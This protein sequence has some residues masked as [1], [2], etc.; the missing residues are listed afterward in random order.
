MTLSLV[1]WAEEA[2]QTE[3]TTDPSNQQTDVSDKSG[4]SKTV[5]IGIVLPTKDE[6]R[7]IQDETRFK[8]ALRS[9]EYSV[10]VLFSQ[11][12]LQGRNR[13]LKP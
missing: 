5:D 10:E 8:D 9:T 6:P 3:Q 1:A 12:I 4:D 2:T 13:M 11:E 7:W